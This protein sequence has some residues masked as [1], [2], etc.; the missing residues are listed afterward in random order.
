MRRVKKETLSETEFAKAVGLSR[1]TIF[2]LRTQGKIRHCKVG[3]RILYLPEHVQEFLK[4]IEVQPE[5]KIEK[6]IKLL[7]KGIS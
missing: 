5:N 4:S 2:K 1:K 6:P 3:V 7:K